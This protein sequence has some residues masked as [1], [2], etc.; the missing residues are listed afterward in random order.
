MGATTDQFGAYKLAPG[1]S[2]KLTAES[3][4]TLDAIIYAKAAGS[5][6]ISDGTQ[7][8]TGS[9]SSYDNNGNEESL[10]I[11]SSTTTTITITN[12]GSTTDIYVPYI[13]VSE[14]NGTAITEKAAHCN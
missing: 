10:V 7:T 4:G 11:N 5:Y 3:A 6:S 14:V 12:T 9:F 1:E 8:I 13:S 2:L